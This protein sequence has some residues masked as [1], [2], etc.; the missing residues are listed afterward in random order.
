MSEERIIT[1]A[2]VTPGEKAVCS[3]REG[4]YKQG[5]K[6][7]TCKVAINERYTW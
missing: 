3:L 5:A 2:T 6:H 1:A 7:K 4:C